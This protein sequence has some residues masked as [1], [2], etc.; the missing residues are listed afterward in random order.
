LLAFGLLV[1]LYGILDSNFKLCVFVVNELIKREI[2]KP[3]D[4][5]LGLCDESLTWRGL[6]LNM[7]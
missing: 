7:I 4:P 1:V 2:E 3:S 6:N 5:L